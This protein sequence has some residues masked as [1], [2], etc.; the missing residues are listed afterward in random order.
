MN[1]IQTTPDNTPKKGFFFSLEPPLGWTA[2]LVFVFFTAVCILSGATTI[3]RNGYIVVS[4]AVALFL[5][6]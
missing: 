4:F 3:L 5:Y 6:L 2:I 1:H